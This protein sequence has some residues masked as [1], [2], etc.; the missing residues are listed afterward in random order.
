[1]R[2]VVVVDVSAKVLVARQIGQIKQASEEFDTEIS[3]RFQPKPVRV[4]GIFDA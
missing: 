1:M 4:L 2:F 3:V